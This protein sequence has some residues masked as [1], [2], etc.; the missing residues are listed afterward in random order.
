M[1]LLGLLMIL[2][3]GMGLALL[4][5]AG[6]RRKVQ[7][8]CGLCE[9]LTFTANCVEAYSM[10]ASEILRGCKPR[11]LSACGYSCSLP[12]ESFLQLACGCVISDREAR[13]LFSEFAEKFGSGLCSRQTAAGQCRYALER[14]RARAECLSSE[15][16][17]KEKMI[18]GVVL[19]ASLVLVILLI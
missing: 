18:Y 1:K 5:A 4:L 13:E 16:P 9:L 6:E 3:S 17:K 8:V 12:P 2:L 7:T 15:L 19:S 11:I 10:T 14:M